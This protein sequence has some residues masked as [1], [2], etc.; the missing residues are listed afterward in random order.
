MSRKKVS[1]FITMCML[2]CAT[3]CSN[4]HEDSSQLETAESASGNTPGTISAAKSPDQGTETPT[5]S[6][7]GQ[8]S[9]TGASSPEQAVLDMLQ[10]GKAGDTKA[11]CSIL[12]FPSEKKWNESDLSR[13]ASTLK[14][15]L[16]RTE[17]NQVRTTIVAEKT[18]DYTVVN[19]VAP[20]GQWIPGQVPVTTYLKRSGVWV[21]E[22]HITGE[23]CPNYPGKKKPTNWMDSGIWLLDEPEK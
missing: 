16:A 20:A 12:R 14:D 7:C 1:I 4:P 15:K 17:V 22:C 19:L 23:P 2:G 13:L 3:A 9:D 5:P 18:G 6:T 10:A 21:H 8:S 11:L